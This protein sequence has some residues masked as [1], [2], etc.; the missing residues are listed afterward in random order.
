MS[1]RVI[2]AEIDVTPPGGGSV[3]TLRFSDRAIRP[4]GAGQGA[5]SHAVWDDRIIEAPSLARALW[6]DFQTLSPGWSAGAMTL[7]NA[8]R[9]LDAWEA[10]SWGAIRV[11]LW[12]PGTAFSAALLVMSGVCQPPGYAYGFSEAPRVKVIMHDHWA[13]L[14][15]P[16]HTQ[17]YAGT[18]DGDTV[19]YEGTPETVKGRPKPVALGRLLDAHLP[20]PQVNTALQA[21]Q[22]YGDI[23]G[24]GLSVFGGGAGVSLFDRGDAAGYVH[25]GDYGHNN[26][27]DGPTSADFDGEA[28]DPGEY[29]YDFAAGRKLIRIEGQ[30]VGKLAFGF[31]V[32]DQAHGSVLKRLFWYA[33]LP[34]S[35]LTGILTTSGQ[36]AGVFFADPVSARDAIGWAA[37][38]AAT[39]LGGV[40]YIA[41]I[42]APDRTG[43]WRFNEVY[44]PGIPG[45]LVAAS[46]GE[47][48]VI[49]L[50]TDESAPPPLG[51][52]AVGWG[53]IWTTYGPADIAPDL[54]GTDK[55]QEL[56]AEYRWLIAE[57]AA[58]KEAWPNA[59]RRI[60]IATP[61]RAESAAQLYANW[62]I[63][64]FGLAPDGRRQRAWRVTLE[65]TQARLAV[66]LGQI[67]N[68]DLPAAGLD[69]QFLLIG[70][71]MMR[72][73][74]DLMVW[75]LWG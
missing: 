56:A 25:A 35:R 16:L 26:P 71:E 11:R 31:R 21:Y 39:E 5:V 61:L 9:A 34:D 8:D 60:E 14:D 22:L 43:V 10:W 74:R 13:E 2:L 6:G 44:P 30:P 63:A 27:V 32:G 29:I 50:A 1:E 54:R 49:G 38:G 53:R 75:T 12:T 67:V 48:D 37:R 47:A 72:P 51:E 15:K 4:F 64:R 65:I 46:I 59:F 17:F 24:T 52:A 20:C 18:N 69:G 66:R 19:L 33:G 28:L 36:H 23:V 42:L 73:R 58:A 70:E 3:Q 62:L 7:A 55:E 45:F 68:I 40:G 41:F 57:D